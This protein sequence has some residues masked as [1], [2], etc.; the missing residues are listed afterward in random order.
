M[1]T[2]I[3]HTP[4][5][6]NTDHTDE[7]RWQRCN[8][9]WWD[10]RRKSRQI[11]MHWRFVH[12][13]P[14][15]RKCKVHRINY[16]SRPKRKI[17]SRGMPNSW[18]WGLGERKYRLEFEGSPKRDTEIGLLHIETQRKFDIRSINGDKYFL[19]I[20]E[21]YSR[22]AQTFPMQSKGETLEFLLNSICK[23]EKQTT[24]TVKK[25]HGDNVTEFARAFEFLYKQGGE[26]LTS[27]RIHWSLMV[28]WKK[29][30]ESFLVWYE[31]VWF[32]RRSICLIGTTFCDMLPTVVILP[33]SK[34]EK[35]PW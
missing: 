18:L 10:R 17:T 24:H 2:V 28:L 15:P 27:T 14:L 26:I 1:A 34:T 19:N 3:D 13:A 23:F 22:F 29:L 20:V 12:L 21:E 25:V 33:Y 32:S 9:N 5:E 35:S 16:N 6:T 30:T 8:F 11:I 31:V 4:V 7:R